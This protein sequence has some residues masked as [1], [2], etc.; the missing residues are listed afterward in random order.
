MFLVESYKDLV[1]LGIKCYFYDFCRV[2]LYGYFGRL[3][4]D[5]VL[6]KVWVGEGIVI[7]CCIYRSFG[8][9]LLV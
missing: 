7:G 1:S 6:R 5:S 4:V 9:L 3:I 8:I 2:W